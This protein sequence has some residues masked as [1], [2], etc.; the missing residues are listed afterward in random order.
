M[1]EMLWRRLSTSILS[2]TAADAAWVGGGLD[3][4]RM[5]EMLWRRASRRFDI[6]E[7]EIE[8]ELKPRDALIQKADALPALQRKLADTKRSQFIG[9]RFD[10]SGFDESTLSRDASI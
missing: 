1:S 4:R 10:E 2:C 8:R 9:I 3:V 6:A 5:S 7:R